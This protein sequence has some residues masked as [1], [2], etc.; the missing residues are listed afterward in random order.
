MGIA[1]SCYY[2]AKGR[3]YPYLE[4]SVDRE[5]VDPKAHGM[6]RHPDYYVR[7]T[8]VVGDGNG[9]GSGSP[10]RQKVTRASAAASA[11]AYE[12]KP[13]YPKT[14]SF[15]V[16]YDF[17]TG[18]EFNP[19]PFKWL[20]TKMWLYLWGATLLQLNILAVL[21]EHRTLNGG[22]LSNAALA[23]GACLTWFAIEYMAHEHVHLYTYDLFAE[24]I[25]FKLLWGCLFFYPQFYGIGGLVFTLPPGTARTDISPLAAVLVF[26][27]FILGWIFTRGA[28]MQK[29]AFK[30][31][32]KEPTWSFLGLV[33]MQMTTIRNEGRI[34]NS[35]FWSISR[36]V[37]FL[38]EIIQSLALSVP[39]TLYAS[40]IG[41]S[42]FWQFVPW[43]YPIYYLALFIPREIED[44]R[45]C[46]AKYGKAWEEYEEQVKW[47]IVPGLW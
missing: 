26:A 18:H 39:C 7:R 31:G 24:K 13:E 3:L 29:F 1:A 42:L 12:Y 2:F 28:N 47:R 44:G 20:D 17:Y 21:A 5:R 27:L 6:P 36:H 8:P 41:A 11:S 19:R 38:G 22:H 30:R 45:I 35:G 15:D 14:H 40:Y 4:T 43:L 23:W 37:N 33:T 34:L 10:T 46:K 32:H 25:G 16:L 9:E